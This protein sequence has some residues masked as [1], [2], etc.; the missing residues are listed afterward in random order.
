M[1][2]GDKVTWKVGSWSKILGQFDPICFVVGGGAIRIRRDRSMGHDDIFSRCV[3]I[4]IVE[5]R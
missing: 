4:A 3:P 5:A 1:K 2:L